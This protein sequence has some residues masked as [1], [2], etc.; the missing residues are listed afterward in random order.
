MTT[1]PVKL[2]QLRNTE[3]GRGAELVSGEVEFMSDGY[4]KKSVIPSNKI[5]LPSR[6]LNQLALCSRELFDPEALFEADE[7]AAAVKLL[8]LLFLKGPHV[9][10][11]GFSIVV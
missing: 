2:I 7:R 5:S 11:N 9:S 8:P 3:E 1:K 4:A 6:W 10:D